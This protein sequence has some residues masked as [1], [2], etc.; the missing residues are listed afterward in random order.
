MQAC[1]LVVEGE[2]RWDV[3]KVMS[4]SSLREF[5]AILSISLSLNACHDRLLW[6]W[7][8]NGRYSVKSRCHVAWR[9]LTSSG[10]KVIG[11]G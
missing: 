10:E 8:K 11:D 5:K 4:L 2:R 7:D 9:L 1:E 6:Y 3:K